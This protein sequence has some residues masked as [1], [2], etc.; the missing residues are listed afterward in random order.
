MEDEILRSIDTKLDA[1]IRLLAVGRIEGKNK[2]EAIMTLG[3]LGLDPNLISE[4]VDTT[5]GTV[6]TRLSE[7]KR[8]S[9]VQSKKI[10]EKV[11]SK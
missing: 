10:T 11:K 1:I 5:P 9:K 3:A 7:A 4:I 8:R 6:H 2:T